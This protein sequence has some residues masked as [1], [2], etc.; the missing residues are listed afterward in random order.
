MFADY[1]AF[2]MSD[3]VVLVHV[4]VIDEW[5]HTSTW[6]RVYHQVHI[7]FS[8]CAQH[9]LQVRDSAANLYPIGLHTC[10]CSANM[11]FHTSEV[12]LPV[13]TADLCHG[14]TATH[15]HLHTLHVHVCM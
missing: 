5:L 14:S 10:A 11:F 6:L 12:N 1:A 3:I 7:V 9:L 13:I 8:L 2:Y 4:L 15:T